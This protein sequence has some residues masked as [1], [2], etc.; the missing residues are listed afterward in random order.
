MISLNLKVSRLFLQSDARGRRAFLG[1]Q[2]D[3]FPDDKDAFD[4]VNHN[5]IDGNDETVR[6]LM[7]SLL[8][9]RQI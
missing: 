8:I 3:G 6:L 1:P 5:T 2:G 9:R 7:K 4:I